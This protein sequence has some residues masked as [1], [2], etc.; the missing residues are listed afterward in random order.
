[1]SGINVNN[2]VHVQANLEK[3]TIYFHCTD[4]NTY[5]AEFDSKE[6]TKKAFI[7]IADKIFP[8]F[9]IFNEA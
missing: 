3:N 8:N 9:I 6:D 1:M 5:T 2:V 4:G 7:T